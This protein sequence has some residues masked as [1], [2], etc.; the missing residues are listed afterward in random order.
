MLDPKQ[1]NKEIPIPLYFQLKQLLLAEIRSG[2]FPVGSAIPTEME[3]AEMFDLSRTTVRQAI[4]ALVQDGHL[5]RVKSKGTFVSQPKVL[6]H[7]FG[8][9]YSDDIR[10]SGRVPG[11]KLL[12]R[13]KVVLTS[14]LKD[15]GASGEYAVFLDRIQMADGKPISRT[16][17]WYPYDGFAFLLDTEEEVLMERGVF[18]LIREREETTP[19]RLNRRF[20]AVNADEAIAESLG[21]PVGTAVQLMISRRYGSRGQVIDYSKTYFRGDM[22]TLEF[23]AELP[24]FQNEGTGSVRT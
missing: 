21:I 13:E 23:E 20:V 22:N 11:R 7:M 2:A 16:M 4:A 9:A 5:Y 6:Y 10:E 8:H 15:M 17:S 12:S 18:G 3:L 1:I 24:G 14:E 19:V